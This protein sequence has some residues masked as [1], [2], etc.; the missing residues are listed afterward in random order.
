MSQNVISSPTSEPPKNCCFRTPGFQHVPARP[1]SRA[2]VSH[3]VR[4]EPVVEGRGGRGQQRQRM[5]GSAA[6]GESERPGSQAERWDRQGSRGD[7]IKHVG[8]GPTL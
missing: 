3:G 8:R 6:L 4:E 1:G 5:A 2:S 7:P